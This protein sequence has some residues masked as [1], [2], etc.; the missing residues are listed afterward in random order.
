MAANF[1][2]GSPL[3]KEEIKSFYKLY[4][5]IGIFLPSLAHDVCASI[6]TYKHNH[7]KQN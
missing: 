4:L 7:F 5:Q 1:A 6:E 2:V 3:R